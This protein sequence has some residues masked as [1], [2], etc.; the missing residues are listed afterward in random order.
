MKN[1][2]KDNSKEIFRKMI[3]KKKKEE[4]GLRKE[5]KKTTKNENRKTRG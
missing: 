3:K 5:I 2:N 1:E 4:S